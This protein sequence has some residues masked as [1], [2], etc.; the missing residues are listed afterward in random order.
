M[1]SCRLIG[2]VSCGYNS[3]WFTFTSTPT[4]AG[5]MANRATT[6]LVTTKARDKLE[7][8]AKPHYTSVGAKL[9]GYTRKGAGEAGVWN[10]RE[11]I[12]GADGKRLKAGGVY[13]QKF[14]G[15][16]DDIEA[17]N[18]IDI[19]S[20]EQARRE[21]AKWDYKQEAATGTGAYTLRKAIE[22]HK[23]HAGEKAYSGLVYNVLR[24]V[25]G[26]EQLGDIAINLLKASQLLKLRQS[27][28]N[29]DPKKV[30]AST[31]SALR[32]WKDLNGCLE[33][34]FKNKENGVTVTV[35]RDLPKMNQERNDGARVVN[36]STEEV[37]AIIAAARAIDSPVADY[38]ELLYRTGA[39]PGVEVMSLTVG[40]FNAKLGGIS[41]RKGK[42]GPRPG[43]GLDDDGVAF[44]TRLVAGRTATTAPLLAREDGSKFDTVNDYKRITRVLDAAVV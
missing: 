24:V 20:F 43:V 22:A 10:V 9:L 3:V 8:R 16:A 29:T 37:V 4:G 12:K 5:I 34:A 39:R 44:C 2:I 30:G 38:F 28:I 31:R 15:F 7:V 21:A 25:E 26:R 23:H 13:K 41:I 18:G 35:W 40:D 14:L 33:Q 1:M 17:A 36:F 11:E 6:D 32:K 19:L 27:W 42:T